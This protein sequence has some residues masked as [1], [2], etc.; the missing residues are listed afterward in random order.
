MLE[1]TKNWRQLAREAL[2]EQ[3]PEKLISLANELQD[4]LERKQPQPAR[5]ADAKSFIK[6][7]KTSDNQHSGG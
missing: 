7:G 3:D 1:L 4:A 5:R 2:H 6:N